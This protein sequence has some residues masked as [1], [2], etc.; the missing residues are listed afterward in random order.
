MRDDI[1]KGKNN[2]YFLGLENRHCKKKDNR[3]DHGKGWRKSLH[4]Q[5]YQNNR[6]F[7]NKIT[8]KI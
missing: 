4:N 2:K 8:A 1:M 3:A 5:K 6:T 7:E